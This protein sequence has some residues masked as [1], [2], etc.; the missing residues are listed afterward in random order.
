MNFS[1]DKF[2]PQS[3]LYIFEQLEQYN[4]FYWLDAGS[5]LKGVRDKTI[6]TSSD[7]DIS[8]FSEQIDDVL[9]ALNDIEERGYR[10]QYNGGYPML[11][12]LI[13]I[14]LPSPVNRASTMDI[15]I[16]YKYE[17]SYVRRSYHKPLEDSKSRYLFGLSKKILNS[18]KPIAKQDRF[19]SFMYFVRRLVISTGKLAFYLYEK[20]GTTLWFVVPKKYFS[21]FSQMKLYSRSFNIPRQYKKYLN[22]RY[23]DDWETPID[24]IKWFPVWKKKRNHILIPKKLSSITSV[25]KYWI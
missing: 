8:I 13:T 19:M 9:K 5:L 20:S 23:G 17:D 14:F 2:L 24:R 12:D 18:T 21:D 1:E 3:I 16:F 6:L 25:K 22:F 4:I 10:I 11:E 7:I 15:Y